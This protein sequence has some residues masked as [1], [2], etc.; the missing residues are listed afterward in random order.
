MKS[1][2]A[3]PCRGSS[4]NTRSHGYANTLQKIWAVY[5][6]GSSQFMI[7]LPI[8]PSQYVAYF[9]LYI[10]HIDSNLTYKSPSYEQRRIDAEKSFFHSTRYAEILDYILDWKPWKMW[11]S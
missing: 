6:F 4:G 1:R 7:S 3:A 5:F 11:L 2:I 8:V 9:L 10:L